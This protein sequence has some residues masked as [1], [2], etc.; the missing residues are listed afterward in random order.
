MNQPQTQPQYKKN[1]N[2]GYLNK[3][4]YGQDSW[5]GKLVLTP[6]LTGL[7]HDIT[8]LAEVK[9]VQ[10]TQYGE[11]RRIVAK[12]YV[13][14]VNGSAPAQ[15]Q[16][17]APAVQQAYAPQQAAPAPAPAP[18]QQQQPVQDVQDDSIPF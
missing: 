12:P 11:C 9:D 17:A 18:V 16:A 1:P 5:Y 7:P 14:K 15:A 6:E 4:S 10:V 2:G 13:P 8:V 3:S